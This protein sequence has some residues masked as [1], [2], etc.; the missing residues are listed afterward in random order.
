[1]TKLLALFVLVFVVSDCFCPF[2]QDDT[3]G[4][5]EEGEETKDESN[6]VDVVDFKMEKVL[7]MKGRPYTAADDYAAR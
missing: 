3:K 4:D 5:A 2:H 7:D 1:M 6:A